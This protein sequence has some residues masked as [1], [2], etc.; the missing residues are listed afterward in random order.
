MF[1]V[2]TVP[3][4]S[5]TPRTGGAPFV[6]ARI[7]SRTRRCSY[8]ASAL[9]ACVIM[10]SNRSPPRYNK[11]RGMQI[12]RASMLHMRARMDRLFGHVHATTACLLESSDALRTILWYCD[13]R[14]VHSCTC[15][16]RND[17]RARTWA[18]RSIRIYHVCTRVYIYIYIY[19][20]DWRALAWIVVVHFS[21]F[22]TP[23]YDADDGA[24]E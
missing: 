17:Y 3:S 6:L 21:P 20:A 10:R 22:L 13:E 9:C 16:C 5:R 8:N 23:M 14:I 18:R 2:E 1:N 12:P 15:T 19:T 11:Y 24:A 4:R 7:I